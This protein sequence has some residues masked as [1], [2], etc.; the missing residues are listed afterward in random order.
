VL[1]AVLVSLLAA[2]PAPAQDVIVRF[3][4]GADASE[5]AGVRRDAGVRRESGLPVA[6]MELV[7]PAAGVTAGEAVAALEAEPEV[8]YAEPDVPRVAFTVPDD[9]LFRF[10]WGLEST[11]QVVAGAGGAADAD[12]DASAA[13]DTTTGSD[14]VTVAVIDSGVAADHPD[15]APNVAVNAAEAGGAAGVDDDANGF[16]DDVRGWDFAGGDADPADADGHGTHVAGTIAARG[17]NGTGVAGMS[18]TARLLPVR[19]LAAGGAG[20]ASDAIRAYAYAARAGAR[21]ANLSFGGGRGLRAERD[22]LAAAP[23]VLFVAA[24]GNEGEDNDVAGSY[25]CEYELANVVC[26]AASDRSDA[27]APFSNRGARSVDL[28]APGVAIGSTYPG[29]RYA[30]LDGTSMAAPHVSGA[31]ALVL[32]AAPGA[33]TA[34]VRAALLDG[35][36]ERP[37]LAGR[38]VTG[39][40]LN[41]AGALAAVAAGP[42][43]GRG[44]TGAGPA[45]PGADPPAPSPAAAPAPPPPPPPG[46]AAPAAVPVVPGP[47]PDR[48]APLLG[49]LR[50]PATVRARTLRAAG[51][52]VRLTVS[53]AA[54]VRAELRRGT[55]TVATRSLRVPR[56]GTVTVVLRP[57][58]GGR[59]RLG[60]VRGAVTLTL[61]LRV[62]DTAGNT[63]TITRRVRVRG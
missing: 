43:D 23:D 48:I 30:L 32:A 54:S 34:Q 29:G 49:R 42:A 47:A 11:G 5:R 19:A 62:A 22:A 53:E 7:D 15:L 56:A 51:V 2:A 14:A 3:R 9:P 41:A 61:R 12:V 4:P 39:G 13:W 21:V 38:V 36:D 52:R 10:L 18:W 60:T 35:V 31:A 6:G 57:G 37:A 50:L 24:A 27:L 45:D 25:P 1:L 44:G 26:V 63:R 40:R 33:T 58:A 59:R 28:A 20:T 55:G 46:P 17:G 16:V 8:L